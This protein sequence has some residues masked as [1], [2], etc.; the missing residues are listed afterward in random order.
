[1]IVCNPGKKTDKEKPVEVKKEIE[2]PSKSS[3][4][5]QSIY[6]FNLALK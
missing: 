4:S 2:K 5:F 6:Y 3:M 1:V